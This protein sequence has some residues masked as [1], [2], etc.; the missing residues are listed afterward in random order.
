MLEL[1]DPIMVE[2]PLRGEWIAPNTPGKRIPS[3]G[4]D[5]L[6]QRFAIDLLQVDRE[7]GGLHFFQAGKMHYFFLGVPLERCLCWG[8]EVHAPINGRVIE[9][10][11][12]YR[13]RR[14]VHLISD[15][16]VVIKN[17]LFLNT[18]NRGTGSQNRYLRPVLGNYIIIECKEN[19]FAMFAHLQNGSVRVKVDQEVATGDVI[20]NVGH[21][22]NSTAPHLH[23][24][25]MDTSDLLVAKGRPFLFREY[26][27]LKGTNWETVHDDVPSD[28]DRIRSKPH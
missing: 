5:Q 16:A 2:L 21:S 17:A 25:F 13:E 10:S 19:L 11:D 22:G 3:H 27:L 20:A 9:T 18:K 6:G 28:K 12:G 8:K 23:F 7:K 15:L 1:D 26:E 4:T 24:Q 14:R